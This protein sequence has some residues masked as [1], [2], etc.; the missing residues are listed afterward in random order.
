MHKLSFLLATLVVATGATAQNHWWVSP[1]GSNGNPGTSGSPFLTIN[2]AATV[3]SAGDVIHLFSAIY[4]N[5]QGN[6]VLGTKNL[7]LVGAGMGATVIKAHTSLD[8]MLPAGPL[9]TPTSE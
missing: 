1:A 3:A 7:T 2:H 9:A 6:V 5:E 4:G 8:T